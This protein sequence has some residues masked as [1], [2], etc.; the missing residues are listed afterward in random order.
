VNV[1]SGDRNLVVCADQV[2]FGKNCFS[3]EVH[4]EVVQVRKPVPIRDSDTVKPANPLFL[5]AFEIAASDVE[6]I[7]W[8]SPRAR[9]KGRSHCFED[10]LNPVAE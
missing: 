4:G 3:R 10:V 6:S 5:H 2:E 1:T 9:E 7:R 8:Q